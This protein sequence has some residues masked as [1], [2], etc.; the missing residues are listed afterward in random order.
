MLRMRPEEPVAPTPT[1]SVSR[2]WPAGISLWGS[3]RR[4][5]V[6]CI[7]P[8]VRRRFAAATSPDDA[9]DRGL[10]RRRESALLADALYRSLLGRA[11]SREEEATVRERAAQGVSFDGLVK[12]LLSSEEGVDQ[13]IARSGPAFRS[14]LRRRFSSRAAGAFGPRLVFLHIMKVGGT[15]LSDSFQRWVAPDQARVHVYMDDLLLTP[16]PILAQLRL[17]AGHIPYGALPLI[18]GPY[19][20]LCVLRDPFSR[21]ISHYT[22]LRA[23]RDRYR[24]VTLDEFV[25][26]EEFDVPSG[27]YQARQLA[28]DLDILEAWRSYSPEDLYAARGGD[29]LHEYPLQSL[30][31][32]LPVNFSDDEL[33]RR[34]TEH[35]DRIDYVGVTDD[36]DGIGSAIARLF[37][38]KAEPM[39][40]LNPSPPLDPREIDIRLRR[41]IDERTAVDR[42]LYQ[43]A[44]QR[45]RQQ[46]SAGI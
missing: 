30:F 3:A 40:R 42:E 37:Q 23:V 18:P 35:L 7:P 27:N 41:R 24:D 44:Q 33:L 4:R 39:P 17:I 12:D 32:S 6:G 43:K 29:P 46:S 2:P 34:S 31:D 9:L 11:A 1:R 10:L 26:N 8:G 38:V 13:A 45:A 36:L 28:H 5:A 19:D 20:T 21:T 16:A 14:K 15:S 22:H 25:S